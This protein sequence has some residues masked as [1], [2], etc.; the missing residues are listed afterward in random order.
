[1][2]Q[3]T[4]Y[5]HLG[6]RFP[7]GVVKDKFFII[8]NTPF[9]NEFFISCITT[10][11]QKWRSDKEGCHNADNAYVLRENYDFFPKKTWVLFGVFDYCAVSQE[12]LYDYVKKGII[13]KKA[14]LREQTIR[15]IINCVGKSEDISG[16]YWSRINR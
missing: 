7:N 10:S 9:Q 4:V 11:Q 14:E 12:L 5:L 3:G 13:I 1:M 2:K 15:A 16:L 8:L 6:Y